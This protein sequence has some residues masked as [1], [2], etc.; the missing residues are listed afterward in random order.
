MPEDNKSPK[1]VNLNFFLIDPILERALAE[2]I[3]NGDIT[4]E[5]TILPDTRIKG[6]LLAKEA[7]RI[8]GLPIFCRVFTLLDPTVQIELKAVE[9]DEVQKG[10]LLALLD[11]PAR[12]ILTG[13][14]VALN[15]LQRLSAIA[16][17]TAWAVNQ[18]KGTKAKVADTRK[19]TPG[20]RIF[21]KYA[22][23]I[24]GGSNHRFN[25]ADGI[26]IKDNHI[27]AAGGIRPAV[28]AARSHAPHTLKVEVEVENEAQI[29][30][31]LDSGADI[32]ML[33]NMDKAGIEAAVAQIAGRALIEISGNMG[34]KDLRDLAATG[35]DLISI[36]ALTHTI[37]AMDISLR[38]DPPEQASSLHLSI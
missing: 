30:Q 36:G 27:Q 11:G 17:K 35:I 1:N 19:T 6:R 31:A 10:D 12:S 22:V 23:R 4:T 7:G 8:C 3:G 20:L 21:E 32:I 14:R 24:G 28:L 26:L 18:V 33:D 37:K 16:T 9:G 34:D 5:S 2:D 13:E 25:L 29:A 38:F 15:F